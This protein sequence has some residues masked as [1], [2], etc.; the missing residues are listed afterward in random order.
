MVRTDDSAGDG[1]TGGPEGLLERFP[2][3]GKLHQP[4]RR[5]RIPYVPQTTSVDCGAACLSMVLGYFGR[6][7]EL[8]EI[9]EVVGTDRDGTDALAIVVGARELGLR[10]R[11]VALDLDGLRYL[12][13]ASVLFWDFRHFV[14]FERLRKGGVDLV[15]PAVGR[16]HL[17]LEQFG[18][19]FTG[20]AVTFEPTE[21]FEPARRRGGKSVQRY[22]HELAAS[23][24][25]LGRVILLSVLVQV[26]GLGLP[27]LTGVLVDRVVPRGDSS[28]LL[29]LSAGLA[30]L[31][32][33]HF[34]TSLIRSHL[35]LFLRT[36]LDARLTL[37]FIEHLVRL[38]Y[39]FFQTRPAGDL[40][41]RMNSNA[42]V[43]EILTSGA[44]STLLDGALVVIYFV[45][46]M[47]ASLPIALLVLFLALLRIL[48][49]V[50]VRKRQ[51]DLMSEGL[52]LEAR[53]SSYQVEMLT[54]METLK[55]M[56]AEKLAA[57]H[58]SHLFVDTLNLSLARG[59]LNAWFDAILNALTMGSPLAILCVGG[60]L[61]LD[62]SLSLGTML[63]AG[64]LAGS[65]LSPL[66]G[67]VNTA[68]EFQLLGSYLDR[69]E[70][71]L[72]TP[73]E[74][75]GEDV[76]PAPPLEGG[77]ELEEVCFRYGPQAPLVIRDV[78]L[79]IRPGSYVAIVGRSGSGKSTL[80]RLVT[81][82][83]VPS[84][85]RI[86]LDGNDLSRL[87]LGSVRRQLGIVTQDP[88]LFSGSIRDNISL[89]CPSAPLEQIAEAAR[90]A[91]IHDEILAMPMGYDTLL[92]D[93]GLSLSGGQR[94]RLALARAL[95]HRPPLL[96]LDEAT[97]EVDTI[98]E[99]EIQAALASLE[100]S[101]IVIAHRLST[102]VDADL[103][104][105]L[106]GGSVA[107]TG[108]YD[109]LID[110][111]GLFARLVRRQQPAG[112]GDE[113]AVDERSHRLR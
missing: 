87:D 82:L 24:G 104:V 86:L 75:E 13:P 88:E 60:F 37:D 73:L 41:N 92:A 19:S 97:S 67:L 83:L 48:V 95:I 64:A 33:F 9:R 68:L 72:S 69:L 85:G 100:A 113:P 44:L 62:G 3:L 15:D 61:V 26:F 27:V 96:V 57:D 91:A 50:T 55:S 30:A 8:S 111:D 38:P 94:Q 42:Q 58:W 90:L 56:G 53:A 105:V 47:A 21:E 10:A 12:P 22:L 18:K 36:H 16:R 76:R 11:S 107:E 7:V 52:A 112:R 71:V 2:A 80:A 29:V 49:F 103:I 108:S 39:G 101:R 25:L 40:M 106:D 17:S 110:E 99:A 4:R 109:E 23:R 34:L 46:L 14:V 77:V 79:K 84:S 59:R 43:R 89:A 35:L 51:R 45:F 32:A 98:T 54:G 65:F 78:S 70:D 20:V 31:V 5:R 93:R 1:K 6:D 28:L 63:A 66:S 102:V 74:Q 81:G